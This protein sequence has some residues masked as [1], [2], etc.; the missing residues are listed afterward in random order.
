M[1]ER[2]VKDKTNFNTDCKNEKIF[3]VFFSTASDQVAM[4]DSFS[5]YFQ[6]QA[7]TMNDIK[8]K[9]N[10]PLKSSYGL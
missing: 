9:M 2:S 5:S 10:L 6:I 4:G 8:Q 7:E 1:T 3:T